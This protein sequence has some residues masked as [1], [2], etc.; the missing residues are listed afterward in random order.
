[1]SAFLFPPRIAVSDAMSPVSMQ[2]SQNKVPLAGSAPLRLRSS[3]M[4][5]LESIGISRVSPTAKEEKSI[6]GG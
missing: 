3:N 2:K 5:L 6:S 1:M 4:N